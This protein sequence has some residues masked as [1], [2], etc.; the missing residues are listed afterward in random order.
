M[1]MMTEGLQSFGQLWLAEL[2][3]G[4]DRRGAS[5]KVLAKKAAEEPL[6]VRV[7]PCGSAKLRFVDAAGKPKADFIPWLQLVVT[8][9]PP[10]WKA[11]EDKTLAAE[12]VT[13]AGPYGDQPPGQPKTDAKGYVTYDGLIPGATYRIKMYNQDMGHN[14]VLKDFRVEAGKTAELEIVV[15]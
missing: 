10:L 6:F 4:K 14:I 13:L 15:K 5:V 11:I 1:L 9:G 3:N 2:V 12:V 8:P 7:A